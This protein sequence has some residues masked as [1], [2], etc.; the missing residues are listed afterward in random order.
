MWKS[1]YCVNDLFNLQLWQRVFHAARL[2]Q[3]IPVEGK[4]FEQIFSHLGRNLMPPPASIGRVTK[5]CVN[6]AASKRGTDG[7]DK[8]EQLLQNKSTA[9][10]NPEIKGL[11]PPAK[12]CCPYVGTTLTGGG[13]QCKPFPFS[14]RLN[15]DCEDEPW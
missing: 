6:L 9:G 1:M 4:V 13:V 15:S 2:F 3:I 10:D 12:P 11:F 7:I 14:A 8:R 5:F